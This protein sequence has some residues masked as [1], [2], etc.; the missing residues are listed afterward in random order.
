MNYPSTT[1][2]E[3]L[4]EFFSV[5]EEKSELAISLTKGALKGL[6]LETR[7]KAQQIGRAH[8]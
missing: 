4:N 7:A 2:Q 3:L 1:P 5:I 8:V 6:E